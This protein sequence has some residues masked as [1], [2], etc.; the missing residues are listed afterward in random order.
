[1]PNVSIP[2]ILRE[3]RWLQQ[4]TDE[5]RLLLE[6]EGDSEVTKVPRVLLLPSSEIPQASDTMK[7]AN[8]CFW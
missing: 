6:L 7:A 3:A 5:P 4:V 1:M 2:M 8:S